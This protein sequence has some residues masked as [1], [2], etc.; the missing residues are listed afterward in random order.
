MIIVFMKTSFLYIGRSKP[1][2][3]KRKV[4]MPLAIFPKMVRLK[5]LKMLRPEKINQ[6]CR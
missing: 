6:T 4:A 2:D 5:A 3:I 1:Q